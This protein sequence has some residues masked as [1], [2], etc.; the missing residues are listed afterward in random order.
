AA[1]AE[2]AALPVSREAMA[3]TA[4]RLDAENKAANQTADPTA[5]GAAQKAF[6][7]DMND[8]GK[9]A[10]TRS[11]LRDLYSQDQLKEQMTWFWM[12]HFNVHLGKRD[13]RSMV[14]DYEDRAVRPRALGH[15]R[16]LLE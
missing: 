2:I 14:G 7:Q 12:N 15:F 4:V 1:E 11:L 5:K 13:I 9:A 6:Q 8:V 10:A 16:D 3:A